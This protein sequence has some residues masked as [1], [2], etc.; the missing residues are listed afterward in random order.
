MV[1]RV[2][3]RQTQNPTPV[4]DTPSPQRHLIR[5][6]AKETEAVRLLDYNVGSLQRMIIIG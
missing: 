4:S 1:S 6:S 3:A 5:G 2:D